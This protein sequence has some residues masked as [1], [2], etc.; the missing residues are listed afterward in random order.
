MN[1]FNRPE[2][3]GYE[4]RDCIVRALSSVLDTEYKNIHSLLKYLGRKEK[5]GVSLKFIEENLNNLGVTFKLIKRSGSLEKLKR[6]YPQGRILC[7]KRG[8]AFP[9]INGEAFDVMSDRVHIK[10]AYLL[11][12]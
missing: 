1:E 2:E 7:L 6:E 8:H 12:E 3:Y 4:K 5:H 10:R 9:L 11:M